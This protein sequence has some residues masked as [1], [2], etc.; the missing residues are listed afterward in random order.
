MQHGIFFFFS[1]FSEIR[2]IEKLSNSQLLLPLRPSGTSP[3]RGRG[4]VFDSDCPSEGEEFLT[5]IYFVH[6]LSELY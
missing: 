4:G 2:K 3:S 5:R 6:E 1:D